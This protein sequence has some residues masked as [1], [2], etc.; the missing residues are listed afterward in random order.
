[1]IIILI[2]TSP[3]KH[4]HAPVR[5]HDCSRH[6]GRH[7][8]AQGVRARALLFMNFKNANTLASTCV[9]LSAAATQ[10]QP[11]PES[12]RC[13]SAMR[14][15]HVAARGNRAACREHRIGFACTLRRAR[16]LWFFR[17]L[18]HAHTCK[19]LH[20]LCTRYAVPPS[21][22]ESAMEIYACARRALR[23]QVRPRTRKYTL[24]PHAPS[25]N[26]L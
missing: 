14:R 20:K 21:R 9:H 19:S 5:A 17:A 2:Q 11:Q 25:T 18:A 3:H 24:T 22:T 26:N 10:P 15:L 8:G 4:T 6:F 12:C 16:F 13:A 1:M 23:R 7:N